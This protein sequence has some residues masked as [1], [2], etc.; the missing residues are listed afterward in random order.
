[1]SSMCSAV[2][3]KMSLTSMPHSAFLKPERR[4]ERGPVLR[5]VV[6]VLLEVCVVA[7][8]FP[9]SVERVDVH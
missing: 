6:S 9:F 4:R 7:F 5:S 3:A 1:M 2:F 8:E